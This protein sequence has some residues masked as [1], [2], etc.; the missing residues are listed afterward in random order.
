M[1][2]HEAIKE[3]NSCHAFGL[4]SECRS[5]AKLALEKQ[6]P[7]EHYHTKIN[8]INGFVRVSVCPDCLGLIYTF[9]DEYPKFCTQCGQKIDWA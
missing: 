5:L 3:L 9:K 2:E 1:T 7:K 6:T 8:N 4:S